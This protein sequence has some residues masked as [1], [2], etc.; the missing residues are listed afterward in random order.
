MSYPIPYNEQ[1]ERAVLSAIQRRGQL[2]EV[3]TAAGISRESF[4]VSDNARV[5]EA[6][7]ATAAAGEK[8]DLF[9]LLKRLPGYEVLLAELDGA[10]STDTNFREWL[11]SLRQF[12]ALRR[13]RTGALELLQGIESGTDVAGAIAALTGLEENA[14]RMIAGRKVSTLQETAAALLA[15]FRNTAGLQVVPFFPA[16]TEGAAVLQ[17]HPGEMM[18][19]GARTGYGKTAFAC[20]GVL[21]QI[22]AGLVVL[23]FCTESSSADILARLAAQ[24]SGV[25]H[26][27]AGRRRPDP[28]KV[29]R[30]AAAVE[31][32]NRQHRKRLFING[33][34]C[35]LITPEIMRGRCR[36]VEAEAGR[37]DV[38]IVDFLQGL[39]A[40]DF[41]NR[42]TSLEQTNYNVQALHAMLA[43]FQAAGVI[44]AQFNRTGQTDRSG[45][46][47]PD[48]TWL[49]D[50]SL[51]EQLAHTVAFLHKVNF[52][53]ENEPTLFYSRKTRNQPPFTKG[54]TL[55]WNG[56]GYTSAQRYDSTEILTRTKA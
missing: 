8:I 40:P 16:G 12:E 35:G 13:L 56:V 44:L 41:M 50:S 33:D 45:N 21:E 52:D 36:E 34:E 42:K 31:E 27:E 1:I 11:S 47:M 9:L 28:A 24:Q 14:R 43:E 54:I 23:Y 49:K 15:R 37:V 46:G 19:I 17:L 29:N 20:G 3:A 51:I 32:I 55:S 10:I 2:F 38:V 30:L 26:F 53:N 6:M 4:H 5:F 18:V 7:A 39:H 22:R 48:I 25:S